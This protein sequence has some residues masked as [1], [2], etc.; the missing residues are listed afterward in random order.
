MTTYRSTTAAADYPCD[1]G[2]GGHQVLCSYGTYTVT[3]A[4][5]KDDVYLMSKLPPKAIVLSG[6]LYGTD[7]DTGTETLEMDIGKYDSTGAVVTADYYH[8]SGV[9]D[10]DSLEH[11]GNIAWICEHMNALNAP[12]TPSSTA[13]TYVGV[14]ITAAANAT[15]TGTFT[16]VINYIVP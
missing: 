14:K 10:G 4:L 16:T 2:R 12:L 11:A 5:V 15:G 13:E 9:I 1:H 6:M 8:N 3:S 7:I